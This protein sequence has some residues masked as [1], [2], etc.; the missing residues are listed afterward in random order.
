MSK[1]LKTKKKSDVKNR[2]ILNQIDKIDKLQKTISELEISCDEKDKVIESVNSLRDD[3]FAVI[4]E[5]K[6]KSEKYD[7][8]ISDLMEMRKVMNQTV[9]KGRWRLVRWLLK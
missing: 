9:F 2:M 5:L 7:I 1:S 8:L 3:L 4:N 6:K